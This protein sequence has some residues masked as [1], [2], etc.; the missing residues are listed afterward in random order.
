M[1]ESLRARIAAG[2]DFSKLAKEFSEDIGS[3]QEGGDLGWVTAGQ[4]VPEFQQVMDQTGNGELSAAFESSFGWHV[5][6]VEDRRTQDL[7]A[8][9]RR[10]QAR[11]ILFGQK[12]EEELAIW[13]QKIRDEAFVEI[14][15]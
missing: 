2:E 12:Y 7:S 3:Q 1:A 5:L 10:N 15:I 8:E 4:M 11:N 6:Q 9:M 14:K 13:L